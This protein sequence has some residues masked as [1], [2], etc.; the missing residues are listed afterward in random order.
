MCCRGE[1]QVALGSGRILTLWFGR[2]WFVKAGFT[3]FFLLNGLAQVKFFHHHTYTNKQIR[4]HKIT[5]CQLADG[6]MFNLQVEDDQ[7]GKITISDVCLRIA[8]PDTSIKGSQFLPQFD[9]LLL[10]PANFWTN[11]RQV[12]CAVS[13]EEILICLLFLLC[14]CSLFN[15]P[16]YHGANMSSRIQM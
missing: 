10:S 1:S 15:G 12:G 3:F 14:I 7:K 5:T 13:K 11:Q 2:W 16:R 9:C 4:W 6:E 8:E